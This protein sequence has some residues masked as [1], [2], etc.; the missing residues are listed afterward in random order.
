MPS[1]LDLPDEVLFLI[2]EYF[3]HDAPNLGLFLLVHPRINALCAVLRYRAKYVRF[4]SESPL[5]DY[6][7][8][9]LWLK[10]VHS[11]KVFAGCYQRNPREGYVGRL[12]FAIREPEKYDQDLA[13]VINSLNSI[14]VVRLEV[15]HLPSFVPDR[16]MIPLEQTIE[17]IKS[18][19]EIREVRLRNFRTEEQLHLA[20]DLAVSSS[21]CA[22]LELA[23]D[24]DTD[25]DGDLLTPLVTYLSEPSAAAN[26]KILYL[27]EFSTS[28]SSEDDPE[29]TPTLDLPSLPSLE[30]LYVQDG[31]LWHEEERQREVLFLRELISKASGL[32][33]LDIHAR[34]LL[35]LARHVIT[36]TASLLHLLCGT[37]DL[38]SLEDLLAAIPSS[39]Q[40]LMLSGMEAIRCAKALLTMDG[41]PS[42]ARCSKV[43]KLT[44]IGTLETEEEAEEVEHLKELASKQGISL[45]ATPHFSHPVD[46]Q[47]RMANPVN[48][49]NWAPRPLQLQPGLLALTPSLGPLLCY[50]A[51]ERGL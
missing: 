47:G 41:Q 6:L 31:W 22:V 44:I 12:G 46:D 36:T 19:R 8:H 38:Q 20:L 2:G 18:R 42:P 39:V 21:K 16:P 26:L 11:I 29:V 13:K 9:K 25:I 5:Q 45:N 23:Q 34:A 32:L 27:R 17:A 40:S 30:D 50:P 15:P 14:R 43:D 33:R 10:N 7:H 24:N 1:L 28:A 51:E 37:E 3:E 49:K 4:D 48:P 35:A